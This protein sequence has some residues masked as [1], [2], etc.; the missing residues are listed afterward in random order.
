MQRIKPAGTIR[1]ASGITIRLA[2]T[3]T[4]EIFLNVCAKI[5]PAPIH[6]EEETAKV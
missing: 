5:R 4:R 2:G 1:E 6:A 3:A